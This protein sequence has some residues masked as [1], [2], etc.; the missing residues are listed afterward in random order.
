MKAEVAVRRALNANSFILMF[1]VSTM[2]SVQCTV[3]SE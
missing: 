1:Y 3:Y 2:Y